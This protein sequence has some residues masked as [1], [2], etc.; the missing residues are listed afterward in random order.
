[1]LTLFVVDS[2]GAPILT[3]RIKAITSFGDLPNEVIR[4]KNY[5]EINNIVKDTPWYGVIYDNEYIEPQ[6]QEALES[7]FSLTDADVL[8]AY[9]QVRY[10]TGQKVF[11]APRFFKKDVKLQERSLLPT[12]DS[13]KFEVILN[14]WILNDSNPV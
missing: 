6:L 9:K 5:A 12:D 3:D 8:V 1:M 2:I 10:A 13:L 7:F 11:K 14:G 4:V